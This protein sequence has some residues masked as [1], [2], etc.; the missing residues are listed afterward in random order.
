MTKYRAPRY[1]KPD[2]NQTLIDLAAQRVGAEWIPASQ[3]PDAGCDRIELYRGKLYVVEIK[4]PA[5]RWTYTESELRLQEKC[6]RQGVDYHTIEVEEDL[7]KVF[8][9]L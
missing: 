1:G 6:K 4:N 5:Q 3:L 8:G 2:A 7:L 9:L